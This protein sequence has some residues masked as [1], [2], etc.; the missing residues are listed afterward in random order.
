MSKKLIAVASAAALAL[1]AL[2]GIAPASAS[3]AITYDG[4][5]QSKGLTAADP[6]LINV[7]SQN[8]LRNATGVAATTSGSV[9][10]VDIDSPLTNQTIRVTST[11]A[12]KLLSTSQFT[13]TANRTAQ[14]GSQSL[15]VVSSEADGLAGFYVYTTSTAV[16]TFSVTDAGTT[17]VRHIKGVTSI[18]NAY[19]LTFTAPTTADVSGTLLFSGSITDAF[20]NK[21]TGLTASA[22][23]VPETLT[24]TRFGAASALSDSATGKWLEST[25]TPGDYTFAV[26]TSATAGP[27]VVGLTIAPVAITALGTPKSSL[28]FQFST[29]S[30]ADQV[31]TLQASVTTLQATVAALTAD[32]NKLAKRFNKLQAAKKA[33]K[34]KVALK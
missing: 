21:I 6:I 23:A 18:D 9:I 22:G 15:D 33:P 11:G 32:Y 10:R 4:A 13:T 3:P 26:T 27:G 34:K 16:G 28:L 14:F 8:V 19:N 1:T 29:S 12:V 5:L 2:V 7:P 24:V 20:G 25:T 30:L 17:I 31:K